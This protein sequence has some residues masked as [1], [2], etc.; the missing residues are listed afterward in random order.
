MQTKKKHKPTDVN[1]QNGSY[2]AHDKYAVQWNN[3]WKIKIAFFESRK[4]RAYNVDKVL[5]CAEKKTLL[6]K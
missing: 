6:L 4:K 1:K 5:S 3:L 2:L